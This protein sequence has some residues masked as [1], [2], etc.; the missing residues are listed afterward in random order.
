VSVFLSASSYLRLIA[1]TACAFPIV[2]KRFPR[3]PIPHH[4][5]F[6]SRHFGTGVLIA[7]AFVHLFPTAYTSLI[8]PCLP[9]FWNEG[10]PAMPGFIAMCS[11]FMVVGI[12][13]FFGMRGAGHIHGSEY[14]NFVSSGEEEDGQLDTQDG[15]GSVMRPAGRRSLSVGQRLR[16]PHSIML[17]NLPE[18]S[19]NLL[20]DRSPLGGQPSPLPPDATTPKVLYD[21]QEAAQHDDHSD[22][23]DDDDLDFDLDELNGQEN[24]DASGL[25]NG[26]VRHHKQ[27][28]SGSLP[29][30]RQPSH[31]HHR[32]TS[33]YSQHGSV[34]HDPAAHSRALL[35]C[36]LL[37]A[38]ILFHSIFIGMA[39]SV[40]T[41]PPFI[42]LLIAISFH[43]TFEGLALGSRISALHFPPSSPHPWLMALA[44]GTTTPIG[45]AIGLAVHR[46]Y[47][48]ASQ[49]GLLVVGL[50][51]AVSS[52]LLLFAGLVELLA[53]DFLSQESYRTLK[54]K[55][56][57]EACGAVVAG[58]M[59]MALVGAWA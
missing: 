31:S 20:A 50:T 59:L 2:V 23:D 11:V 4:F 32:H 22:K 24:G 26:S 13:M 7:T 14:D 52:G 10:Y 5:L 58:A 45:Q 35:Q 40:S 17:A 37:E 39:L 43:Q 30:R 44:Y 48:P 16:G 21:Q 57:L 12:E 38:G 46:L 56:R 51:N 27:S 36:L 53:E 15:L 25:L 8:D 29:P 19:H 18:E 9:F 54:G 28:S 34:P 3:F 42:V 49:T 55:R 33:T 41:G 6:L 1:Q 47:D